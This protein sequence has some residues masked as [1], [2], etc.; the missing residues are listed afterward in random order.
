MCRISDEIWLS[1]FQSGVYLCIAKNNVPPPVSKRVQL[2]VDFPPTLWITHQLVGVE[3]GGV[4]TIECLTAAH[5]KSLNFWHDKYG[6]FISQ[7]WVWNYRMLQKDL[8]LLSGVF[9]LGRSVFRGCPSSKPLNSLKSSFLHFLDVKSNT[10]TL[11]KVKIFWGYPVEEKE[12]IENCFKIRRNVSWSV[13]ALS[14]VKWI[15]NV[16]YQILKIWQK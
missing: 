1:R 4:A 9:N 13:L 8:L 11:T 7:K 14:H 12:K 5:P 16:K 2:Y 6:Q 10:Q 15:L 3:L